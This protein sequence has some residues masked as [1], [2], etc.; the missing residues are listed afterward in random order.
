MEWSRMSG[1]T[2]LEM[3]VVM[4]LVSGMALYGIHG[5]RQQRMALQLEQAGQVLLTFCN[6]RNGGRLLK[7]ARGKLRL[8]PSSVA[9]GYTIRPERMFL[10]HRI[11]QLPLN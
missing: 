11:S 5:F 6:R 8:M 1:F 2:L 3:M 9:C 10:P 4:L 7:T